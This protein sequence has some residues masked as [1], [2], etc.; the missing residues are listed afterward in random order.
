[1]IDN[2][3]VYAV[4]KNNLKKKKEELKKEQVTNQFYNICNKYNCSLNELNKN[5]LTKKEYKIVTDYIQNILNYPMH[6]F[7]NLQ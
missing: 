5:N 7:P 1:M 2:G 3:F 6:Y 4:N